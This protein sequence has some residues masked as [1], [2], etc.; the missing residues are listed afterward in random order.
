[1]T[2]SFLN[3]REYFPFSDSISALYTDVMQFPASNKF[4]FSNNLND[5]HSSLR[6][7]A[8]CKDDGLGLPHWNKK[9]DYNQMLNCK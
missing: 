8:F 2:V 7:S 4:L 1:M 6:G 3:D 9:M 5:Y